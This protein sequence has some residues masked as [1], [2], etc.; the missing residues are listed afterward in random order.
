MKCGACGFEENGPFFQ[1]KMTDGN[2]KN[3]TVFSCPRCGVMQSMRKHANQYEGCRCPWCG[4]VQREKFAVKKEKRY[5][6]GHYSSYEN[7][8]MRCSCGATGPD[9]NSKEEAIE[10]FKMNFSVRL[11]NMLHKKLKVGKEEE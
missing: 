4:N 2:K 3:H 1:F 6:N 5:V 11:A 9:A 10:K 7:F 8:N